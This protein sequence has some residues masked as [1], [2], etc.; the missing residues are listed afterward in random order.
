MRITG[1]FA[2]FTRPEFKVERFSYPVITPSAARGVLEAILWKPAMRWQ[3]LRIK[4]LAPIAFVGFRRNEV[5]DVVPNVDERFLSRNE[6][7]PDFFVQEHRQQRNTVALRDVD[8]VIEA[9]I[10][11]TARADEGDTLAKF[12]SMFRR[13]VWKGQHFQQPYLGCREFAG[14]VRP[15][16]DSVP[17]PIN[18]DLDLGL[19]LWDFDFGKDLTRPIFFRA[20][21]TRGIV[22]V[23]TGL[24][25]GSAMKEGP[26]CS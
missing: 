19:M 20:K 21:M 2:C 23:P 5:D 3:V 8:Y 10:S 11:L 15:A 24:E 25:S 7:F 26:Q 4:V 12:V 18:E 14:E 22:E 17:E 9:R 16:D 6:V 1:P 13:R